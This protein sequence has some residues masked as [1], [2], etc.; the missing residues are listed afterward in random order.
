[1]PRAMRLQ[2]VRPSRANELLYL[3]RLAPIVRDLATVGERLTSDLHRRWIGRDSVVFDAGDRRPPKEAAAKA[4]REYG[5]VNGGPTATIIVNANAST[6]DATIATHVHS[7]LGIDIKAFLADRR[8]IA[9][10]MAAARRTNVELIK[11]IPDRYFDLIDE[12]IDRYWEE[13]TRWE[14]LAG[15]IQEIGGITDRRAALIA[16]DQTSKM[17]AA[18]N[19]I[20]QPSLGIHEYTWSTAH[21]ERVRVAHRQ[22]GGTLQSWANPPLVE[23]EHANPGE[24]VRCRC[25]PIPRINFTSAAGAGAVEPEEYRQAA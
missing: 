23:G 25:A 18:F 20:R 10:E 12:A 16:Q 7:A 3:D 4:R 13:G 2:P 5:T 9:A 14:T 19:R 15:R 8:D 17:N 6:V 22:L 21:D 11:S 24:P 1:M